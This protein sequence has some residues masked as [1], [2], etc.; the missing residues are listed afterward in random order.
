MWLVDRQTL[1]LICI[2]G[3]KVKGEGHK[4]HFCTIHFLEHHKRT[5]SPRMFI[6]V[7][8]L[9]SIKPYTLY[10]YEV[11]RSK[12][13]DT[14]C[15]FVQYSSRNTT[16]QEKNFTQKLHIWYLTC[17]SSHLWFYL[18][19]R[20]KVKVT[21]C[22]F[23]QYTSSTSW[24]TTGKQ[25]HIGTSYLI[26]DFFIITL[27]TLFA[28]EV[29]GQGHRVHVCTIHFKKHY[30]RTTSLKMI[31]FGCHLCYI[32]VWYLSRNITRRNITREF[33]VDSTEI[34]HFW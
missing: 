14:G 29:K 19:M 28:Y 32:F 34:L 6:L 22:I 12:V 24:S 9:L 13:K 11:K 10:V 8:D 21:R 4:V 7:C 33:I 26:C 16:V 3:Q 15:N 30:Q 17:S 5:T 20:S 23:V 1:N 2:W 27:W 18:H 25:L 31:I